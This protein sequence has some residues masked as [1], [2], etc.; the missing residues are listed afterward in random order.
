MFQGTSGFLL[1]GVLSNNMSVNSGGG[2]YSYYATNLTVSGLIVGNSSTNG[3][4]GAFYASYNVNS[5]LSGDFI[6]NSVRNYEG[7]GIILNFSS[8]IAISGN[9]VSNTSEYTVGG[10]SLWSCKYVR[11]TP[12][13]VLQYNVGANGYAGQYVG[14]YDSGGVGDVIQSGATYSPNYTSTGVENNV[15]G[16]IT[17]E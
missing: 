17:I 13:C 14:L 8:N 9:V 16:S 4:G 1:S 10:I 11:L 15:G 6:R 7:G 12:S 2:V 3:G 5:T